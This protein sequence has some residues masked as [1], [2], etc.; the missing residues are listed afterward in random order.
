MSNTLLELDAR[1]RVSLGKVGRA[2]H[3][4]YLVEE[5]AD[6]SVM[7]TP[8][9]VVSEVE[10]KFWSDPEFAAKILRQR[11]E[12]D[13]VISRKVPNLGDLDLTVLDS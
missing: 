1:R 3:T 4:R 11:S 8:A 12:L 2:E 7:L 10:S 9:V 6:G 5:F 13:Q